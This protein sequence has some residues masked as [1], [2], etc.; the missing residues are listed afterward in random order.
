MSNFEVEVSEDVLKWARESIGLTLEQAA[1]KIGVDNIQLMEWEAGVGNPKLSKLRKMADAYKRPLAVLLLPAPPKRFDAL[2][3]FRLLELNQGQSYSPAL[4][5]AFR[6]VEMQRAVALELATLEGDSYAPID[7]RASLIDNTET[8]AKRIREWL[9]PTPS[10]SRNPYR[11]DDLNTWVALI[12]DKSILVT[13]VQGVILEEMRGCSISDQPFPAI[14]LNGKDTTRG[15][16]FTLMHEL[17]HIFLRTGGV[18]DLED[19]R[20]VTTTD[21]ERTERFCNE[22]AAAI[23]MPRELLLQDP[24]VREAPGSTR[25]AD[26]DLRRLADRFGVSAEAMLLRL[27]TL[28]RASWEFYFDR[29]PYFRRAYEEARADKGEKEGGPTFY[30]MKLRD[31]GRRYAASVI[32]AYHRRDIN[33]AELADYLDIKINHLPQLEKLLGAR[34]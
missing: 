26:E 3:D 29:R 33:G 1:K 2:K 5:L 21:I 14:L 15:K 10:D 8:A 22:V 11:H 9:D 19:Y 28:Q 13:Q 24:V 31:F 23:L 25:W 12:E 30:Q 27:V 7:V 20:R 6:R 4:H 16:V 34:R 18:C 32:D 17:V